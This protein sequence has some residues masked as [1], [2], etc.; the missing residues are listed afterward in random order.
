[1][2]LALRDLPR[3]TFIMARGDYP[4]MEGEEVGQQDLSRYRTEAREVMGPA[5]EA[6]MWDLDLEGV[7]PRLTWWWWWWLFFLKDPQDPRRTRQLMILWSTKHTKWIKINDYLWEPRRDVERVVDGGDARLSFDGMTA[8]WWYDGRRMHEPLLLERGDFEV[9][10]EGQEGTLDPRSPHGLRLSGGPGRYRLD[11]SMPERGHAFHLEMTP[12]TPFMSQHRYRA[13]RYT[14]KWSYNILR[15]YGSRVTGR[16]LVDGK[17]VDAAGGTAYFQKVRVNAP[18][19]PWYWCVLHTER[20]D[21]LDYFIPYVGPGVLRSTDRARSWLDH[22]EW[23]V[24]RSLQFWEE[25]AQ[26]VHKFKRTRIRKTFTSDDMPVFHVSAENAHGSIDLELEAYSRAYWRF[27]QKYLGGL[28]RS[29]LYYNEY[30]SQLN[31]FELVVDG[32]RTTLEDLGWTAA[33]CEHT[34]GKLL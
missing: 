11:I 3:S 4:A 12:W 5:A 23:K 25:G 10:K 34:W 24:G 7:L 27:E 1:M 14:R 18:A 19:P 26:R 28:G 8:A 17:E 22:G 20:G 29:I 33:N 31:R 16:Y 9:V 32:R 2:M 13:N 15:I 21:Y 30:P 6:L